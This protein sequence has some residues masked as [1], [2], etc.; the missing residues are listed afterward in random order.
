MAGGRD[1]G[2]WDLVAWVVWNLRT[3]AFGNER[4]WKLDECSLLARGPAAPARK[5]NP[6]QSINLL[7]TLFPE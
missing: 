4:R 3:F 1:R 7:D 5:L 2:A 6:A